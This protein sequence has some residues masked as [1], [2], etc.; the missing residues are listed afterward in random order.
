MIKQWLHERYWTGQ[1]NAYCD[2]F[3]HN[4]KQKI[5]D[6]EIILFAAMIYCCML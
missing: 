2:C 6:K 4:H 3:E 1:W 5:I